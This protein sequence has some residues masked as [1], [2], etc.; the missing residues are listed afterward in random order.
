MSK[1][2]RATLSVFNAS[3]LLVKEIRG[4][5]RTGTS[6]SGIVFSAQPFKVDGNGIDLV[7]VDGIIFAWDG[8]GEDGNLVPTGDYFVRSKT[9]GTDGA[10]TV[11]VAPLT[12]IR[13]GQSLFGSAR[14]LYPNP[15]ID[16]A[17]FDTSGFIAGDH[18]TVRVFNLAYELIREID[19]SG[20]VPGRVAWDLNTTSG[21]RV[22]D[23]IYLVAWEVERDGR[24]ERRTVKLAV[25]RRP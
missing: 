22:A 23:G 17:W 13:S 18:V 2:E 8:K 24:R 10:I 11:R 1:D 19:L 15:V 4:G 5:L 16:A 7:T 3:G 20:R 12:V 6:G 9:Y 25:I 21:A 14:L